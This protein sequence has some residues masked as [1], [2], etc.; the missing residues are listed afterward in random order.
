MSYLIFA[1]V[2]AAVMITFLSIKF[3]PTTDPSKSVDSFQRAIEAL[4]QESESK[5]QSH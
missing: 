1:V 3:R 4:A 2:L 5:G